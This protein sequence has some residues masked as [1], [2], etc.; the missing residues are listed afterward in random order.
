MKSTQ[1]PII[2]LSIVIKFNH[3]WRYYQHALP[4]TVVFIAKVVHIADCFKRLT[5][6]NHDSKTL[7]ITS[8][9]ITIAITILTVIGRY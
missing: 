9:M 2:K 1:Y 3:Y 8:I 7:E 5:S 4:A 6:I